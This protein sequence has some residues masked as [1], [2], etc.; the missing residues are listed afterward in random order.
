MRNE[1]TA[2]F[3][4]AEA[5]TTPDWPV[6]LVGFARV[7]NKSDGILHTLGT[8]V[9]LCRGT[10]Q[11]CLLI[12]VDDIG[13]TVP[14]SNRLRDL[15]AR[16]LGIARG[17]VMVCFSH[18][19]A[20]PNAVLEPR[21][22]ELVCAK[23][24]DAADKAAKNLRPL[25]AAWDVPACDIGVNRREGLYAA[26][27]RLGVLALTGADG[28]PAILVLRAAAHANVL[29]SDNNKL[30]P[31]YFGTVRDLLEGKFGCK[32]MIVQGASGDIR[33]RYQQNNAAALE[34][35][36]I[37]ALTHSY[38]P[39]EREK[40]FRQSMDS[41]DKMAQTVCRAVETVLR[42][43]VPVPVTRLAMFSRQCAFFADVPGTEQAR[44]IADE[45]LREE[46]IDGTAWLAEVERLQK[47]GVKTQRVDVELQ[48]FAV[49]NGCLCGI[50]NETMC[51]IALDIERRTKN[52]LV[53]FGG[54]VNGIDCYLP[55]AEEYDRGGYE[56]LW[57]NLPLFP[58]Y[59]HVMP[60]N[61]KTAD[62][63]AQTVA[64]AWTAYESP[65]AD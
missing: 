39:Q 12:T 7:H 15:A 61:R 8:Q 53:L 22:Y 11:T 64:Q 62:R 4:Y 43:M 42:K 13:F 65:K 52:P 32:V 31:D 21:Y 16:R 9:L 38:T 5:D 51:G 10:A 23:V 2:L 55:T 40:Y 26:D 48:F 60:L 20:G 1:K 6:E 46:Q 19:H 56:V 33:P 57:S 14:L 41:L 37:G 45:A 54:Y 28:K 49:N 18:T 63:L 17:D 58:Y 24:L 30:S 34:V 25:R 3:G 35:G 47:E 44:K 59:G 50:P 27:P 36:G 29:S